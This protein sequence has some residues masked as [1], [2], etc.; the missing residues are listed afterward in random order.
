MRTTSTQMDRLSISLPR[1]Q[2]DWLRAEA[3]RLGVS[4]GELMRR[5][6]D[7]LRHPKT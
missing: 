3:T 5:L 7:E 1:A 4:M 6:I 2:L